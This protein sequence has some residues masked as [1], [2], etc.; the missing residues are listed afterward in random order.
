[1]ALRTA[2][3]KTAAT[4]T[5]NMK[6]NPS[7]SSSADAVADVYNSW[8]EE[9]E[10]PIPGI[11][12]EVYT[13]HELI[14]RAYRLFCIPVDLIKT[15]KQVLFKER[16]RF[17]ADLDDYAR[18]YQDLVRPR[19]NEQLI[20]LLDK[21]IKASSYWEIINYLYRHEADPFFISLRADEE[22]QI[23]VHNQRIVIVDCL[24]MRRAKDLNLH[25]GRKSTR[26]TSAA[27]RRV[28]HDEKMVDL[29]VFCYRRI[30]KE[31]ME[32]SLVKQIE[33][34]NNALNKIWRACIRE[35]I[36]TAKKNKSYRYPSRGRKLTYLETWLFAYWADPRLPLCALSLE[37]I[38]KAA[39]LS[40]E[41]PLLPSKGENA[42]PEKTTAEAIRKIVARAGLKRLPVPSASNLRPLKLSDNWP[43]FDFDKL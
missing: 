41:L 1:M 7:S 20:V 38:V 31:T 2:I 35:E 19:K 9:D 27:F 26:V 8:E 15:E 6:R 28:S 33:I 17:V 40:P 24:N 30:P 42:D 36:K 43:E 37:D 34:K 3:G 25:D 16:E 23:F 13:A 29:L 10:G 14:L 11:D 5:E 18:Q 21:A 4:L 12:F 32:S 22:S 39:Y